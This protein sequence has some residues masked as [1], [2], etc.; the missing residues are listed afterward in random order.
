MT[1][2]QI[3]NNANHALYWI[4]ITPSTLSEKQRKYHQILTAY[5]GMIQHYKM[6]NFQDKIEDLH[7]LLV[8]ALSNLPG[9]ISYQ[10]N[11]TTQKRLIVPENLLQNMQ[12][13][14]EETPLL[15]K[16]SAKIGFFPSLLDLANHLETARIDTPMF[17]SL[18]LFVLAPQEDCY[19]LYLYHLAFDHNVSE[20]KHNPDQEPRLVHKLQLKVNT[21]TYS[22]NNLPSMSGDI[23]DFISQM[24]AEGEISTLSNLENYFQITL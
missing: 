16:I 19:V 8:T 5:A 24:R 23:E 9:L 17:A 21:L 2:L 18:S 11:T 20:K 3:Q 15:A 10:G 12:K 22:L 13:M 7:D 4:N 14:I 6:E 1:V